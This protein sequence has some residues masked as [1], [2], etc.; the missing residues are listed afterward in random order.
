MLR[1]GDT[2]LT[3]VIDAVEPVGADG[4]ARGV[5]LGTAGFNSGSFRM[6]Q[7]LRTGALERANTDS[8]K[9]NDIVKVEEVLMK[10]QGCGRS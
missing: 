8:G 7:P 9:D 5:D 6:T 3:G 4:K 10:L 1:D 2:G